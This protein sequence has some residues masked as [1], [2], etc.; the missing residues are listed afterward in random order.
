MGF[1]VTAYIIAW[2]G[3]FVYLGWIALRLR[4]ARAELAAIKELVREREKEA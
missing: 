4:G 2:V 1:L 3:I